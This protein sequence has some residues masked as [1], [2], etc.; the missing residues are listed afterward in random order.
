MP[1]CIIKCD[2]AFSI[3]AGGDA[4]SAQWWVD[5]TQAWGVSVSPQP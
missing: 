1:I 4:T 5:R 2:G 3:R